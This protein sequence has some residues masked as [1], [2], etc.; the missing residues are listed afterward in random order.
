MLDLSISSSEYDTTE[1][2]F[3]LHNSKKSL[4]L[5]ADHLSFFQ[6]LQYFPIIESHISS[7]QKVVIKVRDAEKGTRNDL[8]LMAASYA[9]HLHMRKTNVFTESQFHNV[10]FFFWFI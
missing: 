5:R 8:S 9:S 3:G 7:V 1:F 2:K 4:F 10:W 6:M